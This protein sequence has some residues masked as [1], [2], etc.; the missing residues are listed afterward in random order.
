VAS[1]PNALRLPGSRGTNTVATPRTSISRHAVSGPE[2]PN[3]HTSKS[4]TSSPRL[5]VTWRIAFAWF[6]AAI[7]S[8]PAAHASTAMP[9]DSARRS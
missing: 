8:T 3:A 7:S 6:H 4:R 5:T 1:S 2:P 9:T